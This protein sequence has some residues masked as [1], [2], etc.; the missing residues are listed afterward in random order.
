[1]EYHDPV[2]LQECVEALNINPNGIYVDATFGGGG[3]TRAVLQRL[4]NGRL[5]AFDQDH[6]ARI[7]ADKIDSRSFTFIEAN[8]RYIK[9]FLKLQGILN[10]DGLLADLG[11]SSHQFD[12][13]D[14][15]FS[16]RFD[17]K[18]D[19]RMDRKAKVTARTVINEYTSEELHRIF[20]MYGEIRN[21]KTL[22]SAIVSARVNKPIETINDLKGII[23]RHA[24]K[25]KE[26]KY[27]AQVFQ[28]IRI[29]VND[30][31]KAL[32]DLL[33]QCAGIIKKGGRLVVISYHSLEDRMVKNFFNKGK[34]FGEA[35]KDIYGNLKRPFEPVN[36]K[37]IVASIEEISRNNRARSAKLRIARKV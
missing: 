23:D 9:Q 1:M 5:L 18:L 16:T 31:L 21:A 33:L 6:D 25:G 13:A 20:G 30:E 37:P 28:A 26:F 7:N 11:V 15:G 19:M 2:M 4:K 36:K 3:H 29:A 10:I 35:E 24:P 34:F 14:R 22:A 17:A 32:E 8:F 12:T 27:Y